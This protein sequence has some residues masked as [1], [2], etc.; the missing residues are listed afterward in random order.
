[1]KKS[2]R[3]R[4]SVIALSAG[5]L[6]RAEPGVG[7]AK[8][9]DA[10]GDYAGGSA[11]APP[12]GDSYQD[13]ANVV[14]T[15]NA[16]NI[17]FQINLAASDGGHATNITTDTTQSYGKYQIGLETVPDGAGEHAFDGIQSV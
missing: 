12:P 1:M 7:G 10:T 2:R 16:T 13:I 9:D 17:F 5:I 8:L 11:T 14:I 15:N 3:S 6:L 4:K